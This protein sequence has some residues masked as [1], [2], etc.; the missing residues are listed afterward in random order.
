MGIVDPRRLLRRPY[1]EVL[2]ALEPED[3]AWEG[4]LYMPQRPAAI[5]SDAEVD[6]WRAR[7]PFT[8]DAARRAM[9]M[10]AM[11][12]EGVLLLV[13]GDP[14][15][16][17]SPTPFT[18]DG[19]RYASV[20]SFYHALKIPEGDPERRRIAEAEADWSL[21]RRTRRHRGAR[22]SHRGTTIAV[23]SSEHLAL[24]ARATAAKVAEHAH[25]REALR[26]TGRGRLEMG[27]GA[28]SQA[29]G[30]AMPFALMVERMRLA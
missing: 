3:P 6:A 27:T 7:T 18:L 12:R 1:A 4:V 25:V 24:V 29:L 22:L 14:L 21:T 20:A 5:P 8:R 10:S 23:G 16:S 28:R 17:E 9:A 30:R 2:A 13:S 26:A 19:E 15:R 11:R